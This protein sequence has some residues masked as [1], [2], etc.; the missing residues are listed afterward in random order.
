MDSLTAGQIE[1]LRNVFY[2][3]Y[4]YHDIE[5][6]VI[7]LESCIVD[8][9]HGVGMDTAHM[10]NHDIEMISKRVITLIEKNKEK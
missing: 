6:W 5:E 4:E 8:L 10:P 9:C 1:H 3:R 7:S 2:G